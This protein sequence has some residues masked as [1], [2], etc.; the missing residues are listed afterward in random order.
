M[1]LIT[2]MSQASDEIDGRM[3]APIKCH[4]CRPI[5]VGRLQ[6]VNHLAGGTE[7]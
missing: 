3:T 6:G 1:F 4:L 5:P 2:K 7:R